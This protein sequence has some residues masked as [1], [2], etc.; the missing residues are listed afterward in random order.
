MKS[1]ILIV[2]DQDVNR[3]MLSQI[4]STKYDVQEAR[5]G[6]EALTVLKKEAP[7]IALILLDLIMPVMNGYD[8][9]EKKN[10]DASLA[11]IPVI[12]TTTNNSMNDELRALSCGAT[13]YI[14]K[15]YTPQVLLRRIESI[16][17]LQEATAMLSNLQHD[18]LTGLMS[19]DYFMAEAKK[20]RDENPDK[21]YDVFCANIEKFRYINRK[22][23][24]AAG[25]KLLK[26]VAEMLTTTIQDGNMLIARFYADCFIG[27]AERRTD[28]EE[29]FLE[30]KKEGVRTAFSLPDV[31]IK[32]GVVPDDRSASIEQMCDNAIEAVHSIKVDLDETVCIFSQEMKER[33]HA[34]SLIVAGLDE[35]LQKGYYE[36]Y[37]QPKVKKGDLYWQNAE[38]LVRLNH[39]EWGFVPPNDFIPVLEKTGNIN[40]L[41]WY[42]LESCCKILRRFADEGLG[43]VVFSVN[44][45]RVSLHKENFVE[46]VVELVK[47][48]GIAPSQLHI[49]VTESVFIENISE[50]VEVLRN[51]GFIIEMDDFGNGY[52]SLNMIAMLPVDVLKFDRALV[53]NECTRASGLQFLVA[54]AHWLGMEVVAEG[55]E[56]Q[57]QFDHITAIGCDYVQGFYVA[58]PMPWRDFEV[59]LNN[60][61]NK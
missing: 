59:K 2:E 3:M 14:V 56:T 39:P 29:T 27:M 52:S 44:M 36:V 49:E 18:A 45:S 41:D 26:E 23:G 34:E 8:F 37:L 33:L 43:Q 5:N 16:L 32:W 20:Q 48:Y 6:L 38:A 4:V 11:A 10:Q 9:L 53:V 21:V 60:Y 47:S 31:S 54:Q 50:A 58:R 12:I 51:H 61:K 1:T 57:E 22:Y 17:K 55:V 30:R 28:F 42:M 15:P 46:R 24:P 19:R 25:D 13:E 40:K 35:A 7:R